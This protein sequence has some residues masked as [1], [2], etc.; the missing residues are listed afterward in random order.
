MKTQYFVLIVVTRA[1]PA[2]FPR[3]GEKVQTIT[4]PED[5]Y[6]KKFYKKYPESKYHD[7]IRYFPFSLLYCYS[8]YNAQ[9]SFQYFSNAIR[10]SYEFGF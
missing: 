4:L 6:V 9:A 8:S 10:S 7:P 2:T 1:P 5:V 3:A